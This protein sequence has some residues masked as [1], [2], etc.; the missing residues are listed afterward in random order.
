MNLVV[1]NE[2]KELTLSDEL[3]GLK[4]F[5][6]LQKA[7]EKQGYSEEHLM[8]ELLYVY[9]MY[10]LRS[11][12]MIYTEPERASM[13]KEEVGL[14]AMWVVD[15][16]LENFI[17][18]YEE[19]RETK[20]SSMLKMT[21][22]LVDKVKDYIDKIDLDEEDKSGKKI[23]NLKDVV[24]AANQLTVLGDKLDKMEA[25]N[26]KQIKENDKMRGGRTKAMLEDGF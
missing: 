18:L 13:I 10:D 23:Y 9:F 16:Y 22:G 1:L 11:E 2:H 12:Y 5:D 24:N 20:I 14:D 25:L 15:I 26:N 6:D 3:Q 19:L 8:A 17:N 21:Y 7:R 4:R